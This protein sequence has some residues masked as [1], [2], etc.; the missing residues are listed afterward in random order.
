MALGVIARLYGRE[1][2]EAVALFTE[3]Q[4]HSDVSSDPFVAYLNQ[5]HHMAA[6]T[7]GASD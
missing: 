5:T 4:W 6:V 3:Y 2:A 7:G 1:R